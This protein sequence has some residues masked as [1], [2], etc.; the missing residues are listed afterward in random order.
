M[1]SRDVLAAIAGFREPYAV[2]AYTHRG[3]SFLYIYI[4]IY[5]AQSLLVNFHFS[6]ARLVCKRCLRA[7][8]IY[9]RRLP[10]EILFFFF[11]GYIMLFQDRKRLKSYI[12][13][14]IQTRTF[15][16]NIVLFKAENHRAGDAKHI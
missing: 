11:H 3:F 5:S 10:G 14:F 4:Y 9:A 8:R 13:L 2:C 6:E 1:A 12:C 7:S 16:R 15:D